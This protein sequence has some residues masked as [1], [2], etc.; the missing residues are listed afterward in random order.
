MY[1]AEC[2]QGAMD[3]GA[4]KKCGEDMMLLEAWMTL[5]PAA[6]FPLCFLQAGTNS[7]VL[8]LICSALPL[9]GPPTP[10]M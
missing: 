1:F 6:W 8:Q 2:L 3:H 4:N 5:L 9:P 10:S 7:M